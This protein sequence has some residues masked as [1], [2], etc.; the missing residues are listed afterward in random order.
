M[1]E[2]NV[3]YEAALDA[4]EDVFRLYGVPYQPATFFITRDGKILESIFGPVSESELEELVSK[5]GST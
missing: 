3:P 1:D 4:S 5:L 2:F